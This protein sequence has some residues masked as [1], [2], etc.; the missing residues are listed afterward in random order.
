MQRLLLLIPTTTYRAKAFVT[1]TDKLTDVRLTMA[2]EDA[3]ALAALCPEYLIEINFHDR[4]QACA[5]ILAY[6]AKY[7]IDGVIGVDDTATLPA[8]WIAE[9]LNVK[10][11][12][13]KSVTATRNKGDLRQMLHAASVPQPA[14]QLINIVSSP[15]D[16]SLT[17]PFPCVIKPLS[18]SASKGVMRCN[19]IDEL[20]TAYQTLIQILLHCENDDAEYLIESYVDGW[21]VA[22]EGIMT[23]GKLNILTIFDKPEPLTGP[24]F[25]ESI[26][27]TPSV[28][29]NERQ[30]AIKSLT[31][32]AMTALGLTDGPIHAEIR[33]ND[34]TLWFIEVAARSIG[35]HCSKVLRFENDRSLEDIIIQCAL[36]DDCQGV[37]REKCA[38]GVMMIQA[39]KAGLFRGIDGIEAASAID[40][41]GEILIS[42]HPNQRLIPLPEGSL[43]I[44]FIFARGET[45]LQV[46]NTINEAFRRLTINIE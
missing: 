10:H 18:L 2:S 41:V 40:G 9:T 24:V 37:H 17:I 26:Y 20:N 46:Q 15:N 5:Q 44:G 7:P 28:L 35:G 39:P 23:D 31:A 29:S 13:V 45:P 33:G 1:A 38:S 42:A 14:F 6:H 11:H 32:K 22:I 27:L 12:T 36:G 25:P 21:E 3:S 8:A 34:D 43:Y 19:N 4:A 16:I 30:A